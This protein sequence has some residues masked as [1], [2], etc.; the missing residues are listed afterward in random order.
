MFYLKL[1]IELLSVSFPKRFDLPS[2]YHC[3]IDWN[4][5]L[6]DSKLRFIQYKVKKKGLVKLSNENFSMK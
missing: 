4:T 6:T 1:Y 2:N 3:H 5:I